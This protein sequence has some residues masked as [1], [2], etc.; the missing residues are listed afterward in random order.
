MR[1]IIKEPKDFGRLVHLV[2]VK[3]FK[4]QLELAEAVGLTQA[5]ICRTESGVE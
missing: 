2:R 1:K 3:K 4:T 5:T